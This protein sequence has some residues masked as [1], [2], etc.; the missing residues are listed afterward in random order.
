VP[1]TSASPATSPAPEPVRVH[2]AIS[3]QN[4][5][6]QAA[7]DDGLTL[8]YAF[9]PEEARVSFERALHA[10]PSLAIAWWGVAMSHGININLNYDAGR[11]GL[12]H[13][14]IAKAQALES[15]ASPV[16]RSLIEAAAV[17]FKYDG[18][19]D[20]DRSAQAYRDAMKAAAAAHPLDDDVDT[21]AAE[22]EMD[23][24]PWGFFNHDGTP[25]DDTEDI[26]ARLQAVIARS[27]HHL[28]AN[29]LMIHALEE[30]P[31]PE[32]ALPAADELAST[33]LE[34]GAEHLMHMPAHAYM[35]AGHYHE[36][37]MANLRAITAYRAY[38]ADDPAG[39]TDYFGHDCLFGVDAFLMS[40]E[41]G[42][43]RD[44]AMLCARH[45]ATMLQFVDLRFRRWD[46]LEKDDNLSSFALGMLAA[47]EG[48]IPAAKTQ[49][50]VVREASD[51][52]S[53]IEASVLGAEIAR[54]AGNGD[55][56]IAALQKGVSAQD[57]TWYS[58]P[59]RFF[60]PVR[61]SLGGALFRAGRYDEA[62]RAFRADLE[63]NPDNPR[64]LYGLEQTLEREGRG[65]DAAATE[66]RLTSA[67]RYADVKPEMTDL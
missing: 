48:R 66:K 4:A 19:K 16:E 14:A 58:E 18:P 42:R 67:S 63:H 57:D 12:G 5:T 17:R 37:G 15:G 61:E 26:I 10:D 20:A 29:H 11:Q 46:A 9:N 6:A 31:H 44:L 28:Q 39:H 38:L 53:T 3:T 33:P 49:L 24:H 65:D 50:A 59:P 2:R 32:R 54:A 43:A 47:E 51:P 7:F 23:V 22:A 45:G 41:A 60:Y 34:D 27:P 8:L 55:E 40:Q 21:L 36:A 13:D 25:I 64:S 62:E 56:E 52:K 30:S 35:R 1:A